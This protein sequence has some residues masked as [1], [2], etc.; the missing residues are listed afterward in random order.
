MSPAFAPRQRDDTAMVG[1]IGIEI[2]PRT[3]PSDGAAAHS[4]QRRRRLISSGNAGSEVSNR[5]W[6]PRCT[7]LC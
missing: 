4:A 1:Q 3:H 6:P 7:P 5:C 2:E